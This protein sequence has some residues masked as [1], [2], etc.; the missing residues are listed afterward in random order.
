[1][2]SQERLSEKESYCLGACYSYVAHAYPL[3]VNL[4]LITPPLLSEREKRIAKLDGICLIGLSIFANEHH[5]L[6]MPFAF[7]SNITPP[8]SISSEPSPFPLYPPKRSSPPHHLKP[9]CLLHVLLRSGLIVCC[10]EA[11]GVLA[12]PR[13]QSLNLLPQLRDRLRVHVGLGN[14]LRERD[15]EKHALISVLV[16]FVG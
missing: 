4:N 11:R 10:E 7:P 15:C 14:E 9:P 6:I 13:R 8:S 2:Y 5:N 16:L 1:M 3:K 12:Q